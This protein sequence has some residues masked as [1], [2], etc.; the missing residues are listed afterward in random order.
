LASSALHL[1]MPDPP[2]RRG[3]SPRSH[4]GG[5]SIARCRA[6]DARRP[7]TPDGPRGGW[8]RSAGTLTVRRLTERTIDD[9]RSVGPHPG[10]LPARGG[11][12]PG[13]LRGPALLPRAPPAVARPVASPGGDGLQHR[14]DLRGMERPP[15]RP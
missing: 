8:S 1:A 14:R 6:L 12:A 10:R 7:R 3:G 15:T 4:D 5:S 13:D 9:D 11:P 2:S